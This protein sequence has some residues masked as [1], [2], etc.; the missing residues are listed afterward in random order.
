[1]RLAFDGGGGVW[2]IW[3]VKNFFLKPLEKEFF[4]RH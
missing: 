4:P 2:M 1:M 3:F